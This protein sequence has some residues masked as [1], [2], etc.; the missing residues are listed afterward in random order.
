MKKNCFALTVLLAMLLTAS[1]SGGETGVQTPDAASDS[2]TPAETEAVTPGLS[3]DLGDYD[4]GGDTFDMLTREY[5]L[6][7][8]NLN[9]AETDGD[10]LNDA[11]YERNRRL[12]QR[13]NF[14]F[15]EEY[16]DF[17]GGAG[18][19]H[20]R[21]FLLAG[22]TSYDLYTGRVINFFT[23]AAEGLIIPAAEIPGINPEKEYWNAQLY[24]NLQ[25][26]GK[27][28]FVVGD[29]NLSAADFTHV[30][31]FN[32]ALVREYQIED[33]YETVRSGN[34][35][36]DKFEELS[37]LTVRDLDG[38]QV[39]DENDQWGYT[40]PSKQV[41]PGFWIA[42]RADLITK[43]AD[44][45]LT[46]V[47][48][49]SEKVISVFERIFEMTWDNG[50]WHPN[51]SGSDEENATA[52][53]I[54]SEGRALFTDASGFQLTTDLRVSEAEYGVLP[55]HKWDTAQ[56]EYYSRIEGCELFGVSVA[57]EN[58]EMAGVIME[59]MACDSYLN[60]RPVYY[61][62]ALKVKGTRDEESVEML[63]IVFKN[64]V[65][66]Y[67]DTLLC[68]ELRDGVIHNAYRDNKPDMVS[69]FTKVANRAQMALDVYN[70]GFAE[71]G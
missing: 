15:T 60:L 43:D 6:I 28:R 4:F 68:S 66:D 29:F 26:A 31:L 24:D 8:A 51:K 7:H 64:R 34:W 46:Y 14:T 55:Y 69:V 58:P 71:N 1:C 21:N 53:R 5:V 39:M 57:H 59:A 61:D 49:E 10:V 27:H 54:F 23:Y 25:V 37:K 52:L 67:A 18:N 45:N 33:L 9:A 30:L 17:N 12:E 22:D 13:F 38:N 62:T 44:G 36:F 40:S 42:A 65:F 2:T 11:I 56:K 70:E 20:P 16:Y 41:S 50:V 48:H 47:A 3:D 19:D 35:T 32:K 63:D